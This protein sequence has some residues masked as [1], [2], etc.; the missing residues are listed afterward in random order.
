MLKIK[1][2]LSDEAQL[3]FDLLFEEPELITF[4][5]E[6]V[7]RGFARARTN[8]KRQHNRFVGDI[9][10]T[11]TEYKELQKKARKIKFTQII[12]NAENM[13]DLIGSIQPDQIYQSNVGFTL[14]RIVK[15]AHDNAARGSE[16][17]C[18]VGLGTEDLQQKDDAFYYQGKK[19]EVGTE[20][21]YEM[22]GSDSSATQVPIKIVGLDSSAT[23][24]ITIMI[25]PRQLS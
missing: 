11:E 15:I 20:I 5:R 17:V 4:H 25:N 3:Y 14:D 18:T 23:F 6:S 19:L 10:T 13:S 22:K 1:N 2:K 24:G 16:V 21:I 9:I 8:Q 7:F 12:F